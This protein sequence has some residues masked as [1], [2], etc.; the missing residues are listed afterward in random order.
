MIPAFVVDDGTLT[1]K[2]VKKIKDHIKGI[3]VSRRIANDKRIK[4]ALSKYKYCLKYRS[5]RF[6]D[7]FYIKLFDPFL[8]PEY[9]KI[10]YMDYDVLFLKR[11]LEI[12]SWLNSN[13]NFGLYATEYKYKNYLPNFENREWKIIE[14]MFAKKINPSFPSDFNSGLLCLYK[15]SYQ[16]KRVNDVLRY[17][18]DVGLENTWTPEQFSLGVLFSEMKSKNIKNKCLHLTR[19]EIDLEKDLYKY[20][21]VHFAYMA[22]NVYYPFALKI[23]L[24]T[25]FFRNKKIYK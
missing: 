10:I 16:P 24:R 6:K 9:K 11:P 12:V 4:K 18:Y 1:E 17:I 3:K 20:E 23:A 21:C 19:E 2:D 15:S 7:R 14:K 22:K 5:E 25:K 13:K 8:L